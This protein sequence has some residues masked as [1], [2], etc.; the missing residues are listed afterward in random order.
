MRPLKFLSALLLLNLQAVGQTS[1]KVVIK[2]LSDHKIDKIDIFDL[3][4]VEVYEYKYND[5]IIAN[6]K[7]TTI[8]CYNLRYFE[9]EKMFRQQLWLDTGK[10]TIKAHIDS[11]KL[12][13]DTVINSPM[14][15]KYKVFSKNYSQVYKTND[16]TLINKFLLETYQ[17]NLENPFSLLVGNIYTGINQNSK[18]N[19]FRLKNL[20]DKQGANFKWFSYYQ[21]VNEKLNSL[22]TITSLDLDDYTFTS[23]ANKQVK[24]SLK[25]AEYF[26]LDFWFLACPPCIKDHISIK[27]NIGKLKSKKIEIISIST[28]NNLI[29]WKKYLLNN[30]YNWQNYSENIKQT[31]TNKLG[32]STFPTYV[33][34]DSN[35]TIKESYNSFSDIL[36]KYKIKE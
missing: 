27:K 35:G 30:N 4:G 20:V 15:Y 36:K 8:D 34:L 17:E 31:L 25:G 12:I 16:T 29:K 26:I 3:S 14:F 24:L 21:M 23:K 11:S 2:S 28:D 33:I 18:P 1:I 13:I 5:T 7:K 6:F 32:I 22:L 10:I 19:L 9:N